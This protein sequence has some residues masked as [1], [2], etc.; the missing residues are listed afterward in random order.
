MGPECIMKCVCACWVCVC[1]CVCWCGLGRT[2]HGQGGGAGPVLGLYL[3]GQVRVWRLSCRELWGL[4]D[5]ILHVSP[6]R[7]HTHICTHTH[8]H[9]HTHTKLIKS[10]LWF[11]D[12][13]H[14]DLWWL[15]Y[16]RG[17]FSITDIHTQIAI[18]WNILVLINNNTNCNGTNNNINNNI[19]I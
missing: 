18:I 17:C 8:T 13:R 11:T 19:N 2:N 6:L 9:T 16:V 14:S 15:W 7:E 3:G 12:D 4:D 5:Q 1:V 10:C